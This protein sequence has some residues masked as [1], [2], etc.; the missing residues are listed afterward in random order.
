MPLQKFRSFEEARRA[1]WVK[2]DDPRLAIRLRALFA[3]SRRLVGI[4]PF[5]SGLRKFRSIEEADT[6]RKGWEMKR[7]KMVQERTAAGE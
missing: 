4:F 6:E 1:L 7:F 5:P 3:F 2:E